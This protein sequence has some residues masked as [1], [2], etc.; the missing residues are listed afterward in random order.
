M[1]V[2]ARQDMR[3]GRIEKI[4]LTAT[5]FQDERTLTFLHKA[6]VAGR[7]IVVDLNEEEEY[8]FSMDVKEG[9]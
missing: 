4:A 9:P 2:V 1:K 6:L 7:K 3:T 8:E 5:H